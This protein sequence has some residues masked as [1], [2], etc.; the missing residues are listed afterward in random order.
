MPFWAEPANE[1]AKRLRVSS[2]DAWLWDW[3]YLWGNYSLHTH[4]HN[5]SFYIK[6]WH[7]SSIFP[8]RR[9]IMA[10]AV[11]AFGPP[12]TKPRDRSCGT[13]HGPAFDSEINITFSDGSIE[14]IEDYSDTDKW[15]WEHASNPFH[16]YPWNDCCGWG[17]WRVFKRGTVPK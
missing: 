2:P 11:N 5:S 8:E 4:D 14:S 1:M 10:E 3:T 9:I 6:D 13:H 7:F 17:F 16:N 12:S 15:N